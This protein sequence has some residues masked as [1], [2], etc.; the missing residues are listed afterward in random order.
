[1]KRM[2]AV[3]LLEDRIHMTMLYTNISGWF[4]ILKSRV[5]MS[6]TIFATMERWY[7]C[8]VQ[9]H[10]GYDNKTYLVLLT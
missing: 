6:S 5:R 4:V 8:P 1:M 10:F 7:N 3:D 2:G 9:H